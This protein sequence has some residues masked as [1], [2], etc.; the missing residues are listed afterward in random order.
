MNVVDVVRRLAATNSRIEKEQILIEA[1]ASGHREFFIG[2]QLACDVLTTFGVRKVAEILDADDAPG[3]FTFEDFLALADKL[4]RRELTGNAARDAIH[5]AAEACHAPTWNEFYRR[6][7]LKDLKVGCDESTIN[8]VLG[9]MKGDPEAAKLMVPVWSCQLAHD[10]EKP[11]HKKKIKGR[12]LLDI[13]LDGVRLLAALDKEAGTVTLYTRNGK[14]NENFPHINE[15][16]AKLMAELP[17]SVMLDGEVVGASFWELMTQVNRKEKVNTAD[18]KLALFDII[19]LDDFRKGICHTPQE[20]RHAVLAEMERAG[21]FQSATGGSVYVIPK[22]AVDLDTEEGRKAMAEFNS[23]AIAAGYEGVMVKDPR[24]PYETKRSAAWLKIK[25]FL[26][27]DLR[28]VGMEEGEADSKYRGML[29]ALVCEGEDDGRF[30]R[31][32]VGSGLTDE[33]RVQFWNE[34][35]KIIGQI[36]EIKADIITQA[37]GE[38]T[39][40]LRFPR[41][42]RFRSLDGTPGTKD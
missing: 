41:F 4:R 5:A 19:P 38:D 7:L 16:L 20:D 9:K 6:V 24:A 30:I 32:N 3:T 31:V 22:V 28:V 13:K 25:P 10:G 14:I 34:R 35:E 12:K 18:A 27:V 23:Q 8:K 2:A 21:M 1:Y 17:G 29:G 26:T 15:G 11:E 39:F 37:A 36:V 42:L 33:Q 40:S